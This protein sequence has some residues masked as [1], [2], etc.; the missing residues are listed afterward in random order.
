M[1]VLGELPQVYLGFLL[2]HIDFDVLEVLCQIT[3]LLDFCHVVHDFVEIE[4]ILTKLWEEG[5]IDNHV[6]DNNFDLTPNSVENAVPCC[7]SDGAQHGL[8]LS[9]SNELHIDN[10]F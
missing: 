7:S 2:A 10:D 5:V 1:P 8:L 4:S 3:V 6:K 9:L